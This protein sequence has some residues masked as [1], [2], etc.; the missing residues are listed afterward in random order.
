MHQS[1]AMSDPSYFERYFPLRFIFLCQMITTTF[2][3]WSYRKEKLIQKEVAFTFLPTSLLWRL[4]ALRAFCSGDSKLSMK[5]LVLFSPNQ[6]LSLHPPHCQSPFP[7]A[8]L[9]FVSTHPH[10]GILCCLHW[11]VISCVIAAELMACSKAVSGVAVTNIN[12]KW[13]EPREASVLLAHCAE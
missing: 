10:P 3:Y 6:I 4:T 11:S 1:C 2:G 9:F 13:F 8:G 12:C 5:L 7:F